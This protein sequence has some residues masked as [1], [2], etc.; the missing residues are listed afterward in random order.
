MVIQSQHAPDHSRSTKYLDR[1][2]MNNALEQAMDFG[3]TYA[4][5]RL[6]AET[7]SS[8]RLKDGQLE[9]AIPGQEIGAT[10]RILADGAWGVHSTTDI[11]N[12]PNEIESTVKLARAVAARRPSG[13]KPIQL[14]EIPVLQD[15]IH[16]RPK[17]DIRNTDLSTKI[18]MLKAIADSASDDEKIVSTTC[19]WSD[20]HIHT[21]LLTSEG[22]DRVWSF[23]RSLVRGMVT[24]RDESEVV[25]YRTRYGGEGGLELI[26]SCDLGQLGSDARIAALRLLK[27]KRAPSGKMPLIA[28]RELTGVYIHEA[29]GHPCEADLVAAG[30]S[31]L[32]G[33]LGQKIGSDIVTVVD[34]PTI[35][36]GY[37]AY[38]IDDEGV[39]TRS[40]QLITNGVLTEYLN[41]RE[42]A[43][44]FEIQPNGG[45]RAQDGLHHPLVRMSN[46]M[47]MGGTHN[48]IDDL[49]EDLDYGIY[50]CGS[51]GGQVDTGKGSFQFAAQEAWL[52][53]NGEITTPLKDVSVSG[54]T[55]E[56]LQNVNGLTRDA[57]LAAPGF[58]G[59]GQ[60]VPVGDGG[61]IM[62]ISE[63]LVG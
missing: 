11:S 16:W 37:G 1:T 43:A 46:T 22:M 28:D 50:A 19:G 34:D 45:A 56:I 38:P 10:L 47:I 41:H 52:I 7:T 15:E 53:E 32:D 57:K 8:V 63:A 48:N 26:E 27:A 42:T 60:T 12:I 20:E 18:E 29:L 5:I 35:R 31:C 21:E 59:K 24:A 2:R 49:M 9:H 39:N 25:S 14:A 13:S 61:P 6:M 62:S 40:K 51:R 30:D 3:A 4:E 58:C 55:L 54:L 23:Q 17:K 44:H 33:K 36:G